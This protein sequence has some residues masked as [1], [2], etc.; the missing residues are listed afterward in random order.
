MVVLAG[1]YR[2]NLRNPASQNC[3]RD[4]AC[5]VL[6]V[7]PPNDGERDVASNGSKFEL[8]RGSLLQLRI[9]AHITATCN[10]EGSF[11]V[12]KSRL[13]DCNGVVAIR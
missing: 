13:L 11:P 4:V 9:Q 5:Y 1:K 7:A 12:F 6:P 8:L 10:F 3:R 2:E